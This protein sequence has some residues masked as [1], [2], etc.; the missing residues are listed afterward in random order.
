MV[1]PS[2][3][4]LPSLRALA[5]FNVSCCDFLQ[6][7]TEPSAAFFF[8]NHSLVQREG[9]TAALKPDNN[10]LQMEVDC[11]LESLGHIHNLAEP[12]FPPLQ[13]GRESP[14]GRL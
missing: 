4:P 2:C 8:F 11:S 12:Q 3:L 9:C 7:N 5:P 13:N 14:L 6:A 10:A 1:L